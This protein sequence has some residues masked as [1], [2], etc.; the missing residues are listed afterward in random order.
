MKL[1]AS[2]IKFAAV[3]VVLVFFAAITDRGVRPAALR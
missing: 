3:S 1:T 2:A